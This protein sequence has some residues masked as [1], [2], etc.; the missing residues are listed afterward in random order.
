[1]IYIHLPVLY[2]HG[3][4]YVTEGEKGLRQAGG[5]FC[6]LSGLSCLHLL[7]CFIAIIFSEF[8]MWKDIAFLIM[9]HCGFSSV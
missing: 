1:M 7:S 8:L 6:C 9:G 2:Y 3:N 5:V 4:L